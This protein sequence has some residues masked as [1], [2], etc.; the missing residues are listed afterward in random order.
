MPNF[1]EY[2]NANK[3]EFES[4]LFEVLRIPSISADE[5]RLSD[6]VKCANWFVDG[7]RRLGL[8]SELITTKR[9]P[10]VYAETPAIEGKPVILVYGHYDVQ[11][12]DPLELWLS[13][14]FEPT[15]RNGNVYARGATDDK[16][17]LLTHFF[18]LESILKTT[19][20]DSLPCQVKFV[21]EGEE[22][23][24]SEGLD[25]FLHSEI[26][27]QKLACDC[28]LVSDTGMIAAGQPTITYGLR[29]IAAFEL[30]LTGPNRDLHSGTFG[31]AVFNPAIALS[32]ILGKIIDENGR[33]QIPHFYDD[34]L[35]L[36]DNEKKQFASLP[37]DEVEFFNA[38]G[39]N[40]GFGEKDFS[41]NE[42]RWV[43]PTFDINGITA[44]YQGEGSKTIIPSKASAK[45]TFRLVPNQK[46]EVVV[47]NVREFIGSVVPVG[48]KWEL[49][50]QHGASGMRLDLDNSRFVQPMSKALEQT[51]NRQPVFI[52]EGGSI[53]IVANFNLV[54]GSD[55]LL[56]G[57][58]QDDD[59][60]HSPNE[61]FSL[62]NFHAGIL[63][64]AR[65]LSY[66]EATVKST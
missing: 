37:F 26:G 35:P 13:P 47:A 2:I 39:V 27:K 5:S 56:V 9:H 59:A 66:V 45:F 33:V 24:G 61:K 46:P 28:I 23:V 6:M 57:W 30:F 15:I 49:V 12:P 53:P 51:F 7:F 22:E 18:A 36:T 55:V 3:S 31:G 50:V 8:A 32:K 4:R 44:G 29:G 65:F 10:I 14:P 58:G 42:R 25:A 40:N 19:G 64:F 43:R 1:E 52:R 41:T 60:L 38:I 11:P 62:F 54:L 48:V 16:G 17:Q 21:V 63:S 34:V 20:M